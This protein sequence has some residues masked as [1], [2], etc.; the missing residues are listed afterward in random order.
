MRFR[1]AA[2]AV[3]FVTLGSVDKVLILDGEEVCVQPQ[4]SCEE[5]IDAVRSGRWRPAGNPTPRD[6]RCHPRPG[7]FSERS[8]CIEG[9]NCR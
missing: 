3:A 7:C 5:A 1:Y 9:Y 2:F 8:L 6:V 4:V